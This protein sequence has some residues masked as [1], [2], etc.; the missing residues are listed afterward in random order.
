MVAMSEMRRTSEMV[1]SWDVLSDFELVD[2]MAGTMDDL[3]VAHSGA[4]R[5]DR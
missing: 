1:E 5:D 3:M 4:R 2:A